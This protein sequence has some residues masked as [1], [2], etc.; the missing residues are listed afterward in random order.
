MG[1]YFKFASEGLTALQTSIVE[2]QREQTQL[3]AAIGISQSTI[4]KFGPQLGPF[5]Q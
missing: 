3:M 2:L 5:M 4:A 1:G